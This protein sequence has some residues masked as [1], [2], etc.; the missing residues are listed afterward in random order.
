LA[1]PL[2]VSFAGSR[3]TLAGIAFAW[4]AV[5]AFLV[6][7]PLLALLG[8]RGTRAQRELQSPAR[9]RLTLLA[10]QFVTAGC[11]GLLLATATARVAGVAVAL[12]GASVL[13]LA[14]R[15]P[16]STVAEV[17]ASVV[18]AGMGLPVALAGGMPVSSAVT[19]SLV[20]AI[21]FSMGILCIKAIIT[22]QKQHTA[23]AGWLGLG[24]AVVLL[25]ALGFTGHERIAAAALPL[26][27]ANLLVRAFA[28]SPKFLRAIGYGLVT[29]TAFSAVLLVWCVRA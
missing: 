16:R 21:A 14:T 23:S 1:A 12:L 10:V 9:R 19:V 7:E 3:I 2:V 18:F 26:V 8:K 4:A 25:A 24:I 17:G 13:A 11:I 27:C 6:R 22:V 15:T 20:W 5:A 28:P 29:A